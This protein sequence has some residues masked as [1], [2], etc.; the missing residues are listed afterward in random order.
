MEG[1]F[2]G[3]TNVSADA[4]KTILNKKTAGHLMMV[5][6]LIITSWQ[7]AANM[8]NLKQHRIL[9][10]S[11]GELYNLWCC[12]DMET[13]KGLDNRYYVLDYARA[14]PPQDPKIQPKY[15]YNYY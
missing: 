8:L 11:S 2:R 6:Y 3:V 13:H 14:M 10:K 7:R 9:E 15:F 1:T 5:S 12:V 4:G